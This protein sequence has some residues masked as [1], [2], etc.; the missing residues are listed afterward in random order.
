[1]IRIGS[2][3]AWPWQSTQETDL[4][5]AGAEIYPPS[6]TAKGRFFVDS[7]G[8]EDGARGAADQV[9]HGD[10]GGNI[11]VPTGSGMS[12]LEHPR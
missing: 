4:Q 5:A 2:R 3:V 11:A 12:G 10:E 1:M 6:S 8:F 9:D 7:C